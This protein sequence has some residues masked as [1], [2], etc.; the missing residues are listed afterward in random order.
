M[1]RY[2]A[3]IND[4]VDEIEIMVTGVAGTRFLL[5]FFSADACIHI[6]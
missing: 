1:M 3:S 2:S 5:N 6:R 4:G